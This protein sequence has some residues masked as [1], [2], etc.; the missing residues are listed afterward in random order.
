MQ[1]TFR[2]ILALK[3][4][5]AQIIVDFNAKLDRYFS[6]ISEKFRFVQARNIGYKFYL[7]Y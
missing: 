2:S 6:F 4:K 7:F 5:S 3:C 1:K